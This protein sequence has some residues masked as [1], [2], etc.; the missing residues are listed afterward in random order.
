MRGKQGKIIKSLTTDTSIAIEH[1]CYG[2][3]DI[4]QF[5]LESG[6]NFVM[7]G[8]FTSDFLEN[9]FGKYRQGSGGSYFISIQ[10]VIE[11]FHIEKTKLLLELKVDVSEYSTCA[12]HECSKCE[13]IT[14]DEVCVIFDLLP[15]FECHIQDNI[16]MALLYIAGY[17]TKD[18]N[19][20]EIALINDTSLYYK[21]YGDFIESLDRGGLK[22]PIDA[23]VQW[24]VF[25]FIMFNA[26]KLKTGRKLLCNIFVLISEMF[27]FNMTRKHG[28]VLSNVLFKNYCLEVVE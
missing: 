1:T 18:D 13:Y 20:D 15:K 7:L 11:K 6:F 12:G 25:C 24:T 16:K 5:L 26:V 8:E 14:D 9:E 28:M 10:N 21:K 23:A 17:V 2:L 19:P 22:I 3:V 4:C 27:A